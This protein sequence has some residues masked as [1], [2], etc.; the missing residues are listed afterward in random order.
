MA[1]KRKGV[2]NASNV[3]HCVSKRKSTATVE[4]SRMATQQLFPRPEWAFRNILVMYDVIFNGKL[5]GPF[6]SPNDLQ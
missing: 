1:S 4:P 3:G 2:V 5:F 6:L